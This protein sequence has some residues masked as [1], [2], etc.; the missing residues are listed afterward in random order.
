MLDNLELIRKIDKD[1]MLDLVY[2]L[3]ERYDKA[4]DI[5][6]D[7]I[8]GLRFHNIIN[9]VIV[10]LGVSF[11]GA[12]IVRIMTQD[13]IVIPIVVSKGSKLPAFVD[14]KTLV[15][16]LSY[17]GNDEE[18]LL[19][20]NEAKKR[21]A[22]VLVI[23]GGGKLK[24]MASSTKSPVITIPSELPLQATIG[25]FF[26]PIL[27]V[28]KEQ[29]ILIKRSLY[30]ANEAIGFLK[31]TR[32][33]FIP[34]VL[35]KENIAKI[36]AKNLYGRLPVIY[37][38]SDLTNV[39]AVRWKYL[40]NENTKCLAFFD[41]LFELNYNEIL[42]CKDLLCKLQVIILG[43]SIKKDCIRNQSD[44]IV[45]LLKDLV[46]G[47]TYVETIGRNHLEQTLYLLLLS[48]YVS[49]YLAILNKIKPS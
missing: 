42:V 2:E 38:T 37:G 46:D 11:L 25:Y 12:E 16:A 17:T 20:Y 29:G 32:E 5:A 36:L 15:I 14:E 6:E 33:K 34:E 47:I 48:D 4:A 41:I 35:Q 21:K 10:G 43:S 45:E 7:S 23:T 39:L 3:P 28:L 8:R 13:S 22:K 18:I 40:L 30:D 9:V 44:F 27:V 49:V 19:A 24:K 31:R 1:N 26:F